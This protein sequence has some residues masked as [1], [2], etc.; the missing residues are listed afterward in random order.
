MLAEA[1]VC[2]R[3]DRGRWI[4][5]RWLWAGLCVCVCAGSSMRVAHRRVYD[6]E[7]RR[8]RRRRWKRRRHRVRR[9]ES[10]RQRV[11]GERGIL[12]EH[13]VHG[14]ARGRLEATRG[15]VYSIEPAANSK[16]GRVR[17]PRVADSVKEVDL[18]TV[19]VRRA[20]GASLCELLGAEH[21][22]AQLDL[23]RERHEVLLHER[24]VA[25]AVSC[26]D[27][28]KGQGAGG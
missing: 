11:E 21:A 20:V 24:V 16:T 2:A 8:K 17:N 26:V 18:K 9:L 6:K 14:G 10:P 12:F 28:G 7:R 27:K 22:D 23:G 3:E 25:P 19:R 4:A 1:A 13:A 15:R 5:R